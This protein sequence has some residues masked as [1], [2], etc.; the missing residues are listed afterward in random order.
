MTDAVISS[1]SGWDERWEDVEELFLT[2][3][4]ITVDGLTTLLEHAKSLRE[5]YLDRNEKL[6]AESLNT[7]AEQHPQCAFHRSN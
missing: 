7:V 5:L 2:G 4:A 3:T 1:L 6:E